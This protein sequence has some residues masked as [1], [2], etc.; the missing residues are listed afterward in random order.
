M[1]GQEKT[2]A[3]CDVNFLFN[4]AAGLEKLDASSGL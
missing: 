1:L 3:A 2:T 4:R